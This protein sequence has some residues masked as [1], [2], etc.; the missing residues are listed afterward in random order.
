V[1]KRVSCGVSAA[2]RGLRAGAGPS[3]HAIGLNLAVARQA[4][5]F[6]SADVVST[7]CSSPSSISWPLERIV[8]SRTPG[9]AKEPMRGRHSLSEDDTA[10]TAFNPFFCCFFRNRTPGP[11]PFFIDE[12]DAGSFEN[13]PNDLKRRTTRLNH[14]RL[15]EV[16]GHH[17]HAPM[18]PVGSIQVVRVLRALPWG[19]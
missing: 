4:A 9:P 10:L 8:S 14:S 3:V 19:Q 16:H 5:S 11:P 1:A 18:F 6:P 17:N 2:V 13:P 7:T 12:L 15:E